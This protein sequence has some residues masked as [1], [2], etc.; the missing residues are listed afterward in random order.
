MTLLNFLKTHEK[1][2]YIFLA[3]VFIILVFSKAYHKSND[4]HTYYRIGSRVMSGSLDIYTLDDGQGPHWYPPFSAYVFPVFAIFSPLVAQLVWCF[5]NLLFLI[6]AFFQI[7]A[8][9][10]KNSSPPKFFYPLLLLATIYPL[11]S[12]F[13]TGNSHMM[14]LFLMLLT[15]R[16]FKENKLLKGAFFLSFAVLWKMTSTILLPY[17]IFKRQWRFVL[18]IFAIT[19]VLGLIPGLFV[20][21]KKNFQLYLDY[22]A[23]LKYF[24]ISVDNARETIQSIT[25]MCLR[26]FTEVRGGLQKVN[27]FN[28]SRDEAF[29]IAKIFSVLLV[30]PTAFYFIKNYFRQFETKWDIE[31]AIMLVALVLLTPSAWMHTY[32]YLVPAWASL[33]LYFMKGGTNK[34]LFVTSILG[35]AFIT[36]SPDFFWGKELNDFIECL[37]IPTIGGLLVFFSINYLYVIKARA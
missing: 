33:I 29:I 4:F 5:L 23:F 10:F 20:G 7:K 8:I 9:Y 22:M 24:D 6:G 27:V 18:Y 3:L 17:F 1:K 16:F 37:S 13:Q 31:F 36:L 14:L 19:I 21:F 11:L 28:F 25:A 32:L 12:N 2:I 30:I 35:W 26:Y 15:Y 34:L